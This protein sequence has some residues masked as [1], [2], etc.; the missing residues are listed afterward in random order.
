MLLVKH[1][2]MS[3]YTV[4]KKKKVRAST[5][6]DVDIQCSQWEDFLNFLCPNEW[7]SSINE[8]KKNELTSFHCFPCAKRG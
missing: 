2:Q 5:L 6:C 7:D 3:S 4:Q 1:G 8:R